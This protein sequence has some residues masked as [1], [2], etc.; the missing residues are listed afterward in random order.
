[1]EVFMYEATMHEAKTNLSALVKRAQSGEEVVITSGRTKK[2]VAR[3]TPI[4]KARSKGRVP[5]LFKGVFT[6]APG[7]DAPLPQDELRLW[8]GEA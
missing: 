5:G 2:P 7:F 3:I 6:I 8:N 4:S 1:M